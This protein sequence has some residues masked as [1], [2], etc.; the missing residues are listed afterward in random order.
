MVGSTR[1]SVFAALLFAVSCDDKGDDS[2]A[3]ESDADTDADADTDT[4]VDKEVCGDSELDP[5]EDCDDG[6]ESASCDAD[7]TAAECGDTT[8]N[9]T[10]GEDCDDGGESATCNADCTVSSCG[11]GVMNATAGEDCDGAGESADCNSDCSVA[12]CGDGIV[13]ATAGEICEP[14]TT[15]V[16]DRCAFCDYYGAGLDGTFGKTWEPLDNIGDYVPAIQGFHY[17]GAPYLYEMA[18]NWRYDIAADAWDYL[19]GFN[20]VANEY[21]RAGA[22]DGTSIWTVGDGYM[23]QFDL[24]TETWTTHKGVIPDGGSQQSAGAVDGDGNIWYHGPDG[25]VRYDPITDTASAEMVHEKIYQYETRIAYDPI[26]NKIAFAGFL[27]DYLLIYDIAKGTF[28][29]SSSNPGNYIHDN[30]CGD[31]SGGMYVGSDTDETAMY[32]YDIAADTFTPLPPLPI[33]HDNSSGCVVSQDGYLYVGTYSG[34][35][36]FRL[37]LGKYAKK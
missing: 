3:S 1:W 23:N 36:F 6:A 22:C 15:A 29:S 17:A 2:T 7:C 30:S 26:D 34:P 19:K 20:P 16:Y 24:A 13:N 27:N 37:P 14:T 31:N 21:Y 28:T 35:A 9:A 32:R 11:D 33:G 10:A 12:A 25:L 5:G 18:L 4:D 8:M